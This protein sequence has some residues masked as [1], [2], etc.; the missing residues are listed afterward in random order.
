VKKA[1][2]NSLPKAGT[3]LLAK[4]LVLF[5]YEEQG[6]IS[7]GSVLDRTFLSYLRRLAWKTHSSGY[8]IGI[9]S[10]V[11]VRKRPIDSKLAKLRAGMFITAHVG[12]RE[13]L[14]NTILRMDIVPVQVVRDPRAILASFVPYVLNDSNHFLHS[15]FHKMEED[16]RYHAVLDGVASSRQK[17]QSLRSCCLALDPWIQSSRT[18]VV[19]FEDIVGSRGGGS[20]I[21]RDRTLNQLKEALDLPAGKMAM[22]S[23]H[24]Y[25]AGR[26]TFRKGQV[27]SWKEE[28]PSAILTRTDSELGDVLD[29]WGYER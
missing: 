18:V 17:L 5:G 25:G 12:Y 22:V 14:L 11:E 28:I 1:F 20:D 2:I 10:P 23:E 27:N 8:S 3:N 16:S 13:N 7:A 24:L 6:H 29:S 4:C 19:R 9:N 21:V 15:M 26:H